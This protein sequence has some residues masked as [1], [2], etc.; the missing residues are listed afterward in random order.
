MDS[1]CW[2]RMVIQNAQLKL[3]STPSVLFHKYRR[4]HYISVEQG[5]MGQKN[6]EWSPGFDSDINYRI[7]ISLTGQQSIRY[8]VYSTCDLK[9]NTIFGL[10]RYCLKVIPQYCIAHPYCA[11]FQRHWRAL[12]HNKR[13]FPQA[14]LDSAITVRFLLNEHGDL[15]FLLHNNSVHIILLYLKD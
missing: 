8:D 7:M 10:S 5:K 9:L 15:Y 11:R 2:L 14:K 12:V 3:N 1:T 6:I 13:N 4:R